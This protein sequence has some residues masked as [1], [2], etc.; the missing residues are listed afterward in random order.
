MMKVPTTAATG[1]ALMSAFKGA[2]KTQA[3]CLNLKTIFAIF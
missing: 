1:K 3:G 2:R